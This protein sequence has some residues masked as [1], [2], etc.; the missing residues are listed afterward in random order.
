MAHA[1]TANA[2]MASVSAVGA[3]A[4]VRVTEPPPVGLD[5]A[6][7]VLA[8][9]VLAPMARVL[10]AR[11][12]APACAARVMAQIPAGRMLALAPA[13]RAMAR[14]LPVPAA[15]GRLPA[16]R[17]TAHLMAQAALA[18]STAATDRTAIAPLLK[19]AKRSAH[20]SASSRFRCLPS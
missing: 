5:P 1:R 8:P 10:M 15:A 9:M 19:S 7:V 12:T 2:V 3:M 20:S 14:I 11:A 4:R 16:L 6:T 18:I 17:A 13:A